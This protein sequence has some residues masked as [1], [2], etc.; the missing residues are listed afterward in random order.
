MRYLKSYLAW[1]LS[2]AWIPRTDHQLMVISSLSL[3]NS[4][5]LVTV[6]SSSQVFL[7]ITSVF[8]IVCLGETL[9]LPKLFCIVYIN[10]IT[11]QTVSK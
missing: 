3:H 11:G 6:R 10:L 1:R 5:A 2:I 4:Y 7:V 9:Q 8:V